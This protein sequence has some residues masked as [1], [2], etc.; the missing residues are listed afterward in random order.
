MLSFQTLWYDFFLLLKIILIENGNGPS[1]TR[2]VLY[3]LYIMYDQSKCGFRL[4]KHDQ[5][6]TIFSNMCIY[7]MHVCDEC[8]MFL[9][10][11]DVYTLYV[12]FSYFTTPTPE[13]NRFADRTALFPN[14]ILHSIIIYNGV[15]KCSPLN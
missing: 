3:L 5:L 9:M 1:I 8:V 4:H 12:F 13:A 2:R 10:W 15:T 11:Q 6:Y 14:W 7:S